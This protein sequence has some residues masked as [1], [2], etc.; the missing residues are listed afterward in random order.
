VIDKCF[1]IT[2]FVGINRKRVPVLLVLENWV[3][4]R[5]VILYEVRILRYIR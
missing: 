1:K 2:A 3:L 5:T 4:C